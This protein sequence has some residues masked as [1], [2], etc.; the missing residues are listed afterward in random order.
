M[1]SKVIIVHNTALYIWKLLRESILNVVTTK[2]KWQLCA[3]VEVMVAII[4]QYVSSQHTVH[5]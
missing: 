3:K 4:S 2:K 1:Y 5:L